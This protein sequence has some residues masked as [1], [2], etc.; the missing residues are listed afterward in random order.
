MIKMHNRGGPPV[1]KRQSQE[2]KPIELHNYLSGIVL[3]TEIR[4]PK[5]PN[6]GNRKCAIVRLS[7]GR[8]LVPIFQE[9]VIIYKSTAGYLF[10]VA[11]EGILSVSRLV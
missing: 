2:N 9:K 8:K 10:V 3:R 1:H 7:T 11:E 5:K 4:H 6:S